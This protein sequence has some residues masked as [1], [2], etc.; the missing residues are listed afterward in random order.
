MAGATR[1]IQDCA[2]APPSVP[3]QGRIQSGERIIRDWSLIMGRGRG[4]KIEKIVG[5]KFFTLPPPLQYGPNFKLPRKNYPKTL[6][7]PPSAWLTPPPPPLHRGKTSHASPPPLPFYSP[8]PVI[9]DQSLK[10]KNTV[11]AQLSRSKFAPRQCL[12]SPGSATTT[13]NL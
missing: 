6:C 7:D 1:N 5:P 2:D 11:F 4:Y 3:G 12:G 10:V 13:F 8:F 9:S